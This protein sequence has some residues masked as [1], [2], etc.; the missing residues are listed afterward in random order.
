MNQF[1]LVEI[2]SKEDSMQLPSK[3]IQQKYW[4]REMDEGQSSKL[5]WHR[6]QLYRGLFSTLRLLPVNFAE[7]SNQ[8]QR[9]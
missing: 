5:P 9:I 8:Q 3:I 6:L 2:K 7:G 4:E 1:P